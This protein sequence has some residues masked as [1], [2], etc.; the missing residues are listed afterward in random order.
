[1]LTIAG[2]VWGISQLQRRTADHT[3]AQIQ[4]GEQMLTAMLDQET[5]LRGFA[6]TREEE[7]LAPYVRGQHDFNAASRVP[8]ATA[9]RTSA[10]P[11]TSIWAPR[12]A[13][14]SWRGKRSR[15]CAR[16]RKRR[17]TRPPMRVRKSAFERYR[18]LNTAFLEQRGSSGAAI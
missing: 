17:R 13:G 4:A 7:F 2:A 10:K 12:E 8:A 15:G 3:F 18:G 6:L 9:T 5:G 14:R 11:L 1:M 16:T